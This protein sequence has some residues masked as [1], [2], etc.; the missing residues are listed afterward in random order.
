MAKRKDKRKHEDAAPERY[1]SGGC[2]WC[3]VD[4]G[5]V[6]REQVQLSEEQGYL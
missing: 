1:C 5:I 4:G 2:V 3:A 6:G